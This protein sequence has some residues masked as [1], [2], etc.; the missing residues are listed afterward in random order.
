MIMIEVHLNGESTELKLFCLLIVIA[1]YN[2]IITSQQPQ[3][4]P[5]NICHPLSTDIKMIRPSILIYIVVFLVFG[6]VYTYVVWCKVAV[7]LIILQLSEIFKSL[8][9]QQ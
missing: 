5:H 9:W 4:W 1:N 3:H 2:P 8:I 7:I 6:H